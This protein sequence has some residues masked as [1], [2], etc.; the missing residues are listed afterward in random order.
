MRVENPTPKNLE[1]ALWN[2]NGIEPVTYGDAL[3]S[4]S[5]RVR[6]SG[7]A[8]PTISI[9]ATRLRPL[10]AD[11]VAPSTA[12]G[13]VA[14]VSASSWAECIARAVEMVTSIT[15]V[16]RRVSTRRRP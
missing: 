4:A 13:L 7:T 5:L 1:A 6:L 8:L 15:S 9:E 11:T 2:A 16:G 12:A 14:D 10:A 3:C